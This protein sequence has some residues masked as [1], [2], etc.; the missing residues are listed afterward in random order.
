MPP[1]DKEAA[2][3]ES[4][5]LGQWYLADSP[6]EAFISLGKEAMVLYQWT[7]T[8]CFQADP[9]TYLQSYGDGFNARHIDGSDT[10]YSA[11]E[12]IDENT[13]EITQ[14]GETLQFWKDEQFYMD[15]EGCDNKTITVQLELAEIP[16]QLKINRAA[17]DDHYVELRMGL[18]LDINH[19]GMASVGDLDMLIQHVKRPDNAEAFIDYEDLAAHVWHIGFSLFRDGDEPVKVITRSRFEGSIELT[20]N[21]LTLT[22]NQQH[23][24][25][26]SWLDEQTPI[27]ASTMLY[28]PEPQTESVWNG[29]IDGPWNWS[30]DLHHDNLPDEGYQ[31][32]D[33]LRTQRDPEGDQEGESRWVD[34]LAVDVRLD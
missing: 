27:R 4:Q 11:L 24:P 20:G 32:I 5:Y 28:Y 30:S 23:H 7:E 13:L 33:Y 31:A 19:D 26:L 34:I 10:T 1:I 2:P 16:R 29:A 6:G 12:L 25:L 8:G 17:T 18:E 14:E 15:T 21:T 9:Y 22:F 3:L